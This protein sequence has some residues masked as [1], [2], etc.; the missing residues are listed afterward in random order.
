[1]KRTPLSGPAGSRVNETLAPVCRPVPTHPIGLRR[2]LWP[3]A[4]VWSRSTTGFNKRASCYTARLGRRQTHAAGYRPQR[5]HDEGLHSRSSNPVR[6]PPIT[7]GYNLLQ[8]IVEEATD[9]AWLAAQERRY[10][11]RALP[12]G[13][14]CR[15]PPLGVVGCRGRHPLPLLVAEGRRDPLEQARCPFGVAH[16]RPQFA[17]LL[18]A[19][20]GRQRRMPEA[21]LDP[22]AFLRLDRTSLR[23]LGFRPA[24]CLPRARPMPRLIAAGPARLDGPMIGRLR[25]GSARR[26]RGLERDA[27]A[28]SR[29]GRE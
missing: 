14:Q 16:R 5:S 24:R 8:P 19:L 27:C 4:V 26:R 29:L 18:E 21:G 20:L 2:V 7:L 9:V 13:R 23:R 3:R 25:G 12:R 6:R 28:S 11:V 10:V 17:P 22:A 1:M 15:L